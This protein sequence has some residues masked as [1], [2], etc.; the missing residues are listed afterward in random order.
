DA[1]PLS[2]RGAALAAL[3][4]I[5]GLLRVERGELHDVF[6]RWSFDR[7]LHAIVEQ[8]RIAEAR[9]QVEQAA[10][11]ESVSREPSQYGFR[12]GI[13]LVSERCWHA[14]E[15]TRKAEPA[16]TPEMPFVPTKSSDSVD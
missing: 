13:E 1:R 14:R 4:E 3:P 16:H 11:V 12:Q 7:A 10:S 5:G 2:V 8:G 15:G 6:L 9:C